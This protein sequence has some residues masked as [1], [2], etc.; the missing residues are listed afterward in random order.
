MMTSRVFILLALTINVTYGFYMRPINRID[1]IQTEMRNANEWNMF[2]RKL[3]LTDEKVELLQSQRDQEK[4]KQLLYRF[5]REN[6]KLIKAEKTK[7]LVNEE[8]MIERKAKQ[9]READFVD[10]HKL[11]YFRKIY[12]K[13][14]KGIESKTY[15]IL[16]TSLKIV[17]TDV[18]QKHLR[19]SRRTIPNTEFLKEPDDEEGNVKD[20]VEDYSD[21]DEYPDNSDST[22][23]YKGYFNDNSE[24]EVR[25]RRRIRYGS[26]QNLIMQAMRRRRQ[27]DREESK[28]IDDIDG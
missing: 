18:S 11:D 1:E 20:D 24:G 15:R 12:R 14:V 27:Q 6:P 3:N 4:T 26:I 21:N 5:I 17:F 13:V 25:A 16:K 22:S 28:L 19:R 7:G 10:N 9:E 2:K 8:E 23:R